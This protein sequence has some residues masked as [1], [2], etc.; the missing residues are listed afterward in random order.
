MHGFGDSADIDAAAAANSKAV[1]L[2]SVD[3]HTRRHACV[4]EVLKGIIAVPRC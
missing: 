3:W 1:N 4:A 2:S